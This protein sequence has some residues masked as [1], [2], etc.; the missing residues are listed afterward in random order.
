MSQ[1]RHDLAL[2]RERLLARSE[3]A[4]QQLEVQSAAL[5][6]VLAFG[7]RARATVHWLRQHPEA[8]F[9]LTVG[10]IIVRPRVAWRWGLRA[11]TAVRW[12]RSVRDRLAMSGYL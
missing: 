10:L 8:V 12:F 3:Q 6:P 1:A 9:A 5:L 11:W 7:D 4:R 2:R